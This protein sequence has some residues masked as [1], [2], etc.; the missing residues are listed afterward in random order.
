[1]QDI[2]YLDYNATTPCLEEVELVFREHA[3]K[4]FGNP[5]SEHFFGK[6]AKEALE[7]YRKD[8]A[9]FLEAEPEEII[10]TSGGTESNHLAIYGVVWEK[11]WENK[12]PHVLISAFEHPS[13]LKPI[14][15]IA[16]KGVS[17]DFVPVT[18]EG[19]VEVDEVK[20]RIKKNTVF[21]SIMFANNEIGTIQPVKEIAELCKKEKLFF[22]RMHVKQ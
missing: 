7:K 21:V 10:F 17:I 19:Y 9:D 18:P 20:K 15:H 22:I 5:S 3:L 12:S 11:L 2:I 4:N 14:E 16:K 13:V 1:M 8:V 6:K